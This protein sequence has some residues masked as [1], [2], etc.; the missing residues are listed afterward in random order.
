MN[1]SLNHL[2][3]LSDISGHRCVVGRTVTKLH[4]VMA[5]FDAASIY[6]FWNVFLSPMDVHA[7]C[8]NPYVRGIVPVVLSLHYVLF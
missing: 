2:L 4:A 6:N 1:Y 8:R 3:V 7:L 5:R